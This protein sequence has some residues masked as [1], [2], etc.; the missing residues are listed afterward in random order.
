MINF[1][2]WFICKLFQQCQL[3]VKN[4]ALTP[5]ERYCEE[6]PWAAEAKMFD[7]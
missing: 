3:E 4:K 7:L 2:N 1:Y 5:F 6:N